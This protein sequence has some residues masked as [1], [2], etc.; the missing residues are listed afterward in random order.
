MLEFLVL[1]FSWGFG[2]GVFVAVLV[3][4]FSVLEFSWQC[5]SFRGGFGVGVFVAVLV[6][7]FSV[8]EFSWRFRCWSFRWDLSVVGVWCVWLCGLRVGRVW[9]V[10][11]FL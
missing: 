2:V 5:W 6:L 1:K 4:E 7:E 9:V 8:L 11:E 3:L 10:C